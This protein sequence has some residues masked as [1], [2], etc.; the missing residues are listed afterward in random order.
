MSGSRTTV[1]HPSFRAI[2]PPADSNGNNRRARTMAFISTTN[3][4]I[5]VSERPDLSKDS[6]LQ[7]LEL[8][9]PS[10]PAVVVANLYNESLPG[11]IPT[12]RTIERS[13][14]TKEFPP[15]TIITGDMNAHHPWWNSAANQMRSDALVT[16][17]EDH[18]YAL[19][20]EPDEPTY[21]SRTG[22]S[23]SVIDLTFTSPE[24][25]IDVINW[26]IDDEAH[27]GSDHLPIRFD[28]ISAS[29]ETV[30]SPTNS[31]YNWKK[32]D[33]PVFKQSFLATLDQHRNDWEG[34]IAHAQHST[35]LDRAAELL[36]YAIQQGVKGSTPLR[37]NSPRAKNWWTPEI[38]TQRRIMH[39]CHR[40]WKQQKTRINWLAYTTQRNIY[41]RKIV[42]SKQTC[43]NDFLENAKGKDIFTALKY[44]KPQRH[45]PTPTMRTEGDRNAQTFE[46]KCQ[47][48]RST[49][50]PPPPIHQRQ[51]HQQ[52][53]PLVKWP[54]ITDKEVRE[55]IATSHPNKSPGPDGLPFLCIQQAY[56]CSPHHFNTLYRTLSDRGYHPA[57]WRQSITAVIRKGN[58][59]DYTHAKAY[60]PVALLNCLGKVL[61]KIFATRLSYLAETDAK[62]LHRSQVGGRKQRSAIDA[63]MSL[64]HDVDI[65][66]KKKKVTSALFMDVRGAYDNVSRDRLIHTMQGL[67]LPPQLMAWVR[68]FLSDRHTALAFDGQREGLRPVRTGIPQGSPVSPVLFLIYLRPLFDLMEEQHPEAEY[69]SYV[70]DVGI[71]I[72]GRDEISNCR[73]LEVIVRAI[74]QWSDRNAITFD[75]PKTELIHFAN[76][77]RATK[78]DPRYQVSL[79][80]GTSIKPTETVRWLG[81]WLDSRLSFRHHIH[82]KTAAATRAFFALKRLANSQSGLTASS[83]R[84]LYISTVLP[85]LDYGSEVWWLGQKS[86]ISKMRIVQNGALRSVLGAFRTTPI[87]ALEAEASIVPTITR[88]NYNSRRYALRILSLPSDH[89]IRERCPDSFPP[90]YP[91]IRTEDDISGASWDTEDPRSV[92]E[93]RLDRTLNSVAKWISPKHEIEQY[94]IKDN[95]PWE[96]PTVRTHISLANK[97]EATD[98]HQQFLHTIAQ[99]PKQLIAYGDGSMTD[100]AVGA[101]VVV[102]QNQQPDL[103]T[104]HPMGMQ[105]EVYDAELQGLLIAAQ[106]T[107]RLAFESNRTPTDIWI[108]CDNQSAIRRLQSFKPGPGQRI[109]LEI[110]SLTTALQA[111][112]T[113]LHVHWVPGHTDIVGNEVADR[114]AKIATTSDQPNFPITTLSF[115]RRAIRAQKGVDWM[116]E[117]ELSHHGRSY[118]G[119]PT[120]RFGDFY[121]K[122]SRQQTSQLLAMRTGHGYFKSYLHRIPSSAI[123]NPRCSC[124]SASQTP[125]HLLLDCRHFRRQRKELKR[126]VGQLPMDLHT[127]LHTKKGLEAT[128]EFLAETGIGTR[129]WFDRQANN[130]NQGSHN[131]WNGNEVGWGRLGQPMEDGE[132][133]EE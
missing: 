32:T 107:T 19:R 16:W 121:R 111:I 74:F 18:D 42:Q 23:Q 71:V 10:I 91:T 38:D 123:D 20:N 13:L 15:R 69:P 80:S 64:V 26:A 30:E 54:P 76:R 83:T 17:M 33:W 41:F 65:S 130:H 24:V 44:T 67:G 61:E 114:L 40:E 124:G 72:E 125:K 110:N 70:D 112:R 102:I 87:A 82:L 29:L 45:E 118:H 90:G 56:Q 2:I 133:G 34:L 89:P 9:T 113:Q 108:F 14:V 127:L 101:G 36:A 46:E 115:L 119:K 8:S 4:Y 95:P 84:Q 49:M 39:S 120:L 21:Y 43:W 57:A 73:K 31:K 81:V 93:S 98:E 126:T 94:S 11:R 122:G 63:V 22:R 3:P 52:T 78:D 37:F 7:V 62:I 92:F 1:S 104:T 58:K 77:R 117:W 105:A 48:F 131:Q 60:R 103:E 5:Q 27:T 99:R 68:S 28:I 50:F 59:P 75:G 35:N 12:P 116:R 55:A 128:A 25:D 106:Q 86:L 51:E 100:S 66:K 109:S 129:S 88:L 96:T 47:L 79:P 85:V 97:D 53:R 132:E 6:D